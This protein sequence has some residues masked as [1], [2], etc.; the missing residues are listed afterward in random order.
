MTGFEGF[1]FGLCFECPILP[2][3]HSDIYRSVV[4]SDMTDYR[5]GEIVG[6]RIW[7]V[8]P[9]LLNAIDEQILD[10]PFDVIDCHFGKRLEFDEVIYGVIGFKEDEAFLPC[11]IKAYVPNAPAVG[12][13]VHIVVEVLFGYSF[14]VTAPHCV[15]VVDCP[16]FAI[17]CIDGEKPPPRGCFSLFQESVVL[18]SLGIC[19][20]NGL[21]NELVIFLVYSCLEF[22]GVFF[23]VFTIES[24]AD[25]LSIE[26]FEGE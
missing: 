6:I 14:V 12:Q 9:V 13:G 5:V 26:V 23:P 8:V 11:E 15:R 20:F 17:N 25:M 4:V 21:L 10:I 2:V 18:V 16:H 7:K 24:V 3:I 19:E 22:F 1:K